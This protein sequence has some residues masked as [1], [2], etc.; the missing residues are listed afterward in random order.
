MREAELK[1]MVLNHLRLQRRISRS[2]V[3]ANEFAIARAS[4]RSD[5]AILARE[6]IGIEIKSENDT[7]RRLVPQIR[8]YL[9]FFDSVMLFVASKHVNSIELSELSGVEVWEISQDAQVKLVQDTRAATSKKASLLSLLTQAERQK[10]YVR[11]PE[12]R[13]LGEHRSSTRL[14]DENAFERSA[15]ENAFSAR[16]GATSRRFWES[17]GR[18]KINAAD[19]TQL[20]RYRD[21]RAISKRWREERALARRQWALQFS[22]QESNRI[23]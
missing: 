8:A 1:A 14:Q 16:F 9:T 22:A 5:L 4:V 13:D 23:F 21:R 12:I 20:S 15:F 10:F 11:G 6:F 2:A 18:R 7:L 17:V 3:I 19:L